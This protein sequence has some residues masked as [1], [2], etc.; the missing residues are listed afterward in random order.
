MSSEWKR[1]NAISLP[2]NFSKLILKQSF[3]IRHQNGVNF[4]LSCIP[5]CFMP[6][7]FL[8]LKERPRGMLCYSQKERNTPLIDRADRITL[9]KC[10]SVIFPKYMLNCPPILMAFLRK[11]VFLV[12][13]KF[14]FSTC[15]AK[16]SSFWESREW[17]FWRRKYDTSNFVGQYKT[18]P[19]Y[20]LI[21]FLLVFENLRT[22]SIELSH[23]VAN[24]WQRLFLA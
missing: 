17:I 15:T 12:L 6:V 13:I 9:A 10:V 14:Y 23:V 19:S 20:V 5:I 24:M 16:V 11:Q 22:K 1:E 7:L 18:K 2:E 8:N 21:L 3:A 4:I